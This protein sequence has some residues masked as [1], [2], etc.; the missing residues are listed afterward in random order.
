MEYLDTENSLF[1]E[2]KPVINGLGYDI[3]EFH[4][5]LK[6][7]NLN[8]SLR[9][10]KPDGVTID[11]CTLVHR[12]IYPR[13]EIMEEIRDITLEISSPGT[14]RKIKSLDEF[15]IFTGRA[16]SILTIDDTEW[17]HGTIQTA[18]NETLTVKTKED[19]V[20]I[21]YSDIKKAKLE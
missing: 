1:K 21:K 2:L 18:E 14:S 7:G 17:I 6:E 5:R 15:S 11:D 10:Y 20:S 4:T 8:L 13:I 12:T 9:I 16:V 3:V 19:T